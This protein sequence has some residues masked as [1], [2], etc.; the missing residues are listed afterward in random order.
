MNKQ[1]ETIAVVGSLNYDMLFKVPRL[2]VK[3]ETLTADSISMCGGGKG[4]NQAVQCAKLGARTR[5]AGRVGQDKFGDELL[6]KLQ[7]FGVDI[8]SV[9]RSQA[10]ATGLASVQ[11]L[12]GGSVYATIFT[13]ANFDLDIQYVDSIDDM[14]RESKVV[15]LQMEIP[16]PVIEETIRRASSYGCYVLLNAAPAKPIDPKALQMVDCLVV[17]EAEASF[18][19]G[20]QVCDLPSAEANADKLL[21]M[22]KGNVIITLGKHGSLLCKKTDNTH[23]TADNTVKAVETTGA[24]DSYVGALAVKALEGADIKE[25]CCFASKVADI[26]VTRIGAQEGMPALSELNACQEKAR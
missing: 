24:G 12:P 18:Y 22:V 4:A 26:T 11:V 10:A 2:P 15:I 8:S 25:A 7:S 5:M 6:G 23:F 19:T 14:L 21:S 20:A 9:S 16:M 3:G 17:N 13:G 1:S